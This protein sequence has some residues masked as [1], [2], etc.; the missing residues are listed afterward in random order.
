MVAASAP[1]NVVIPSGMVFYTPLPEA[2]IKHNPD[3]AV[4]VIHALNRVDRSRR[5]EYNAM[6]PKARK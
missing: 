4:E 6:F 1:A 3:L 5:D 2:L